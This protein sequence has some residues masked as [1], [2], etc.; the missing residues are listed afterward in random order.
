M[1][2]RKLRRDGWADAHRSIT[3][4]YRRRGCGG[5]PLCRASL[6]WSGSPLV[7]LLDGGNLVLKLAGEWGSRP[8]LLAVAAGLSGHRPGSRRNALHEPAQTGPMSG[9]LSGWSEARYA[10]KAAAVLPSMYARR[11]GDRAGAGL[12]VNSTGKVWPVLDFRDA[13]A[14]YYRA[15]KR[16]RCCD[17]YCDATLI[18]CRSD[19]SAVSP[20]NGR[21]RSGDRIKVG[22]RAIRSTTRALAAR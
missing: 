8:P 10:R 2:M 9:R 12:L 18:L 4:V 5:A 3:P 11:R 17:G 7:G 21:D 19:R 22:I 1:N 20:E 15:A 13:E 6:A 16:P 14:Y